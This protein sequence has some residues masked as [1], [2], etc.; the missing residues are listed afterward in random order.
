MGRSRS[1][2]EIRSARLQTLQVGIAAAERGYIQRKSLVD[3]S[4]KSALDVQQP[5]G[6]RYGIAQHL[7]NGES[8]IGGNG[9]LVAACFGGIPGWLPDG[10]RCRPPHSLMFSG[11]PHKL[12]AG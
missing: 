1:Q 8:T 3:F 11:G 12:H 10:A 9:D 6:F 7:K 5:F 2:R 4:A